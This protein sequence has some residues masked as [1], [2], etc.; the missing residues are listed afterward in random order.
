MNTNVKNSP[1]NIPRTLNNVGEDSTQLNKEISRNIFLKK[2]ECE[3]RLQG[4]QRS[5]VSVDLTSLLIN[6]CRSATIFLISKRKVI[7]S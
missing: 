1:R 5:L 7:G 6:F 4:I 3:G 2:R